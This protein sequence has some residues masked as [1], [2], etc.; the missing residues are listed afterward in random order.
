MT[1]SPAPLLYHTDAP[2]SRL[3]RIFLTYWRM[4]AP[5][6]PEPA[7]QENGGELMFGVRVGRKYRFD[8]AWPEQ[9]V[10]VEID[11]GQWKASGGRHA[12][13]TD[14]EKHNLAVC[15][16]WRVLRYSG[17]MLKQDPRQCVENVVT[18]LSHEHF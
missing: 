7:C 6:A 13:D 4:F 9:M 14:R 11:G 10:A 18:V 15:L 12:R 2:P 17:E 5:S 3:E 8:F 16:G 1:E